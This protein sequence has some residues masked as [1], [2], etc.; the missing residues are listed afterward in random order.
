MK[1]RMRYRLAA[2]L[3]LASVCACVLAKSQYTVTVDPATGGLRVE[4]EVAAKSATTEFQIPNWAPG[5]YRLVDTFK[6]LTEVQ[7]TVRG[8]P[9]QAVR[10]DDNT[11]SVAAAPGNEIKF[12]YRVPGRIYPAG[13][14]HWSG[15]STYCYVVG[16]L[17]EPAVLRLVLP[18]GWKSACGL[19]EVGKHEYAAP[20]YDV[21][22]D[23]P[24]SAGKY[25]ED[26]YTVEGVPHQI[27]YYAGDA[28]KVDRAKVV[29]V[30]SHITRAQADFWGGLPFKKY[31]W[32]FVLNEAPD[33]GW[34]LEHLSSTQIGLATGL[35]PGT[36]SVCSHEYF[37]AWNVKRIRPKM[38]GPFN[39]LELPKTGALWFLE[40]VTDYY[41]DLLLFRYGWFD[42]DYFKA[43]IVS[44]V[45]RT[46]A[47]QRRFEVSPYDSSYRVGEAANGRGNSSGFGVNYY[48]TGWVV[49]LCLDIEMRAATGGKHSLDDVMLALYEVCADDKPGFEEDEIRKQLVRFGGERLGAAYDKWVRQPGE[50]PVEEQLEKMG[51]MLGSV[52]RT[53]GDLGLVLA[54]VEDGLRVASVA[55]PSEGKLLAGDVLVRVGSQAL[56]GE[57][58]RGNTNGRALQDRLAPGSTVEVAFLRDGLE[59]TASLVVG[60]RTVQSRAVVASQDVPGEVMAL[61]TGWYRAGKKPLVP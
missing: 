42:E 48:N 59:K 29:E 3:A 49:G 55:G 60:S 39:Y 15:P 32:H 31:V 9:S 5:S 57:G 7:A 22:A 18:E 12:S 37:H 30:L 27:V 28:S 33:G 46:R 2:V 6:N 53:L 45:D 24:V 44:N 21:L 25:E 10:K 58:R 47:N 20:G 52:P 35:G 13:T 14:V 51:M 40:G 34:G 43:N 26:S 23:N 54:T 56:V 61:R 36:I 41:A 38:L 17:D 4:I 8:A 11:W 50:L 1:K 19:D 16:R